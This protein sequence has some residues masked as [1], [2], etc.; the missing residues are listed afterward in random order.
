V[1]GCRAATLS[2]VA[3]YSEGE[4]VQEVGAPGRVGAITE[5]RVLGDAPG[6][7]LFPAIAAAA[8][9]PGATVYAVRFGDGAGAV[10]L[11]FEANEIEPAS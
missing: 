9:D 11:I 5:V 1:T 3:A 7:N 6:P 4:R 8:H 2:Y 10:E